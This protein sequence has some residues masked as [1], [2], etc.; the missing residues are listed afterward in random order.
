MTQAP[1]PPLSK[2]RRAG[3]LLFLAGELPIGADGAVPQGIEAQTHLT[4]DRIEATLRAEGL[5]LADI[6]SVTAYLVD[7][8]D[9]AAFNRAYA[10]RLPVPYPVRTTVRADLMRAQALLELT[11]VAHARS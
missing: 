7:A 2:S 9:F 6:V 5:G 3:D 11:V 1:T 4:L 8:A 10:S